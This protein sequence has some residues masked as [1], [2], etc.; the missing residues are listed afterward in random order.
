MSKPGVSRQLHLSQKRGESGIVTQRSKRRISFQQDKRSIA[1]FVSHVEPAKCLIIIPQA[2]IDG[3]NWMGQVPP[4]R[5]QSYQFQHLFLR[6]RGAAHEGVKDGL[7]SGNSSPL[8][9]PPRVRG[10]LATFR[11]RYLLGKDRFMF[12]NSPHSGTI[13]ITLLPGIRVFT[14]SVSKGASPT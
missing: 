11:S 3:G 2:G 8:Q 9:L 14:R 10:F 6:L 13:Q 7:E 4:L 12:Y 1:P 5:L